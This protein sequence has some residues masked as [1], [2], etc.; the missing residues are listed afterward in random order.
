MLFARTYLLFSMAWPFLF[1]PILADSLPDESFLPVSAIFASNS[2][3]SIKGG[4]IADNALALNA[5]A[6]TYGR[7]Q[8]ALVL[9]DRPQLQSIVFEGNSIDEWLVRA[10]A[11]PDLDYH[12]KWQGTDTA[13]RVA[14]HA[15]SSSY[16]DANG[17]STI[18]VDSKNKD[19][20]QAGQIRTSEEVLSNLVYE[21]NNARN[22][23]E[24]GR[25][26]AGALLGTI[27]RDDY[28]IGR[29]HIEYKAALRT[30]DF[31]YNIW[32]PYSSGH[33]ISPHP[34]FWN[35]DIPDSF[36][37]HLA[38]YP[39]TFWYPWGFFGNQYDAKSA[40]G[41]NVIMA[42]ANKGDLRAE[43]QVASTYYGLR[44]YPDAMVWYLKMA[45]QNDTSA[46]KYLSWMYGH[47]EGISQ[48]ESQA[49]AWALKAA[50]QGDAQ[51]ERAVGFRYE[52]GQ[53][54]EADTIKA[55]FWYDKA[56]GG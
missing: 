31:Y 46:E 47:G 37:Q 32:L 15:E 3:R 27:S 18:K 10:F 54:V 52:K 16:P 20:P 11:A 4:D 40:L 45:G 8:V 41:G 2:D 56:N 24:G 25:L 49:F 12:L 35:L 7:T 26:A 6:N 38:R 21:L 28:I 43:G 55:K 42:K 30:K 19:G 29:A 34:I 1:P 50:K 14:D 48:D 36:E 51:A 5:Q 39:R 53:G 23:R 22:G 17:F 13:P 9:K 33:A 44:D